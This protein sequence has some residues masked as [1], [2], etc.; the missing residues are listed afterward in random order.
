MRTS[1]VIFS[2]FSDRV[3]GRVGGKG[4]GAAVCDGA[5]LLRREA[6]PCCCV[7]RLKGRVCWGGLEG[8]ARR[9]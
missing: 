8:F 5:G 2:L 4:G 3:S 9:L 7:P 1:F 6:M